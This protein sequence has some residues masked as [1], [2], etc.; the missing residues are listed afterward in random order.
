MAKKKRI[1]PPKTKTRGTLAPDR[2]WLPGN[3]ASRPMTAVEI[4]ARDGALSGG[5]DNANDVGFLLQSLIVLPNNLALLQLQH[6]QINQLEL[7]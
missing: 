2:V 7:C 4:A 1:T 6:G 5:E 3:H